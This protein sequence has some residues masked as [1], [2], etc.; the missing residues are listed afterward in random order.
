MSAA[1]IGVPLFHK[2]RPSKVIDG[3]ERF[4][5]GKCGEF[6]P[7]EAFYRNLRTIFGLTSAGLPRFYMTRDDQEL[8]ATVHKL[9]EIEQDMQ[10]RRFG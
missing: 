5:C 1:H 9:R 8:W 6:K 7:R 10:G 2:R 3:V 4:R